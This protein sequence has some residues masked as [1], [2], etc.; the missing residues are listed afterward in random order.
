MPYKVNLA[1]PLGAMMIAVACG[2]GMPEQESAASMPPDPEPINELRSQ[3]QAAY[4]AGDAAGVAALFADDAI[5]LPDHHPALEGRPAIQEYYEGL[6][7]EYEATITITPGE[8]EISRDLAHEHGTYAITVTP[9]AGGDT[10]MDDGKYVIILRQGV[11]GTWKIHHD[12][13]NSNRMPPMPS[14]L[15]NR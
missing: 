11:D 9:K 5:S 6:F 10:V 7:K 14:E 1:M 8:T 12:I 4:N 15:E 13:D 2:G 3:F